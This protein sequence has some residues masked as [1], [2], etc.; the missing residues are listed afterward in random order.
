MFDSLPVQDG[1]GFGTPA[2]MRIVSAQKEILKVQREGIKETIKRHLKLL[3]GNYNLD[4]ESYSSLKRRVE[5]TTAAQDQLIEAS[6]NHLHA[7][8]AFFAVQYRF[9]TNEDKL[10]RLIFHGDYSKKPIVI[11]SLK[12]RKQ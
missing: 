12:K 4:I 8:T 11:E 9:I 7:D 10:A 5:L 3:V 1:V 6:K 2:S